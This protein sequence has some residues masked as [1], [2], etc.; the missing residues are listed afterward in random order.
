MVKFVV[1]GV[2]RTGTTLI[3]TAIDSHPD[4]YC[5]GEVFKVASLRVE[6]SYRG[7]D[8]YAQYKSKNRLNVLKHYLRRSALTREYLDHLYATGAH[9]AIGFKL[10][11]NQ[12]RQFPTIIPYLKSQQVKVIH[13]VRENTLKTLVSRL[14]A[15]VRGKYHSTVQLGA[16]KISL[17]IATLVKRLQGIEYQSRQWGEVFGGD[18]YVRVVYEEFVQNQSEESARIVDYIGV[19]KLAIESPLVKLNPDDLSDIV[20]NY[21]QVVRVLKGTP[22]ERYL[23]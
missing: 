16:I 1:V 21:D 15:R 7:E 3:R 23:G 20:E 8:G 6:Q 4:I 22:F 17:P 2:Q 12:S 5:A 14:T 18:N 11:Y 19:R 13:V 10:M 9:Q